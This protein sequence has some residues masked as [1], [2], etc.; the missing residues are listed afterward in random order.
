VTSV[1]LDHVI[2]VV[3][4]PD[5]AAARLP[6]CTLD[7]GRRHTGQ[8]TSNRRAF[9]HR[10]YVEVLWVDAPT[11]ERRSGLGIAELA[12]PGGACPFG[13][14]LRGQVGGPDRALFTSYTVPDGS[15][16][17]LL[18]LAAA[19]SDP[20]L[21]FVAVWETAEAELSSRWPVRRVSPELLA[22][23]AGIRDIARVRIQSPA[24]PRLGGVRPRDVE[25]AAG[26]AKL[27]LDLVGAPNT[28]VFG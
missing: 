4:G 5:H 3:P 17:T 8:G 10:S 24:V 6:G 25:F 14:V 1:E 2:L 27:R 20:R 16:M 13:V 26:V 28:W 23:P 18:L 15:G 11:D 19:L 22:H 7:P 21:P 9:F 12:A